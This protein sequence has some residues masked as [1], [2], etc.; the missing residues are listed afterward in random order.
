MGIVSGLP[1]CFAAGTPQPCWHQT[2]HTLF[3]HNQDSAN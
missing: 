2:G 3:G 1:I